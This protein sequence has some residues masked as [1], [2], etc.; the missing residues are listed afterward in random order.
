MTIPI[1]IHLLIAITGL[2]ISLF[3]RG[4]LHR[5]IAFGIAICVALPFLGNRNITTCAFVM[6]GFIAL[7]TSLYGLIELSVTK[8]EKI[9]IVLTGLVMA[10]S[11][12]MKFQHLPGTG[13]VRILMIIPIASLVF[14]LIKNKGATKEVSFM[15]YWAFY[16]ITELLPLLD[17]HN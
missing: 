11:A 7:L 14:I 15:L 10:T 4:K 2:I 12:F 1:D 13:V 5:V 6:L 16:G 8:T 9:A 17:Q 3:Y